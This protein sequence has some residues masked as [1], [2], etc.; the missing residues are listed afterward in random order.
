MRVRLLPPLF[1][2]LLGAAVVA[3]STTTAHAD[4][5][6]HDEGPSR[7]LPGNGQ[8]Q[9]F[10]MAVLTTRSVHSMSDSPGMMGAKV[11]AHM[12][13][14][15]RWAFEWGAGGFGGSAGGGFL[16]G[17][18]AMSA[19]PNVLFYVTP[20]SR[21]QVYAT[22]GYEFGVHYVRG[23]SDIPTEARGGLSTRGRTAA[24]AST[25]GST[26]SGRCGSRGA[27]SP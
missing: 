7:W 18:F 8:G 17:G 16:V 25:C 9:E 24:P 15:P 20:R 2:G 3:M 12:R 1:L 22:V 19:A 5:L 11:L 23:G 6:E 4:D 21:L 10:G 26:R 13:V 14:S 27:P